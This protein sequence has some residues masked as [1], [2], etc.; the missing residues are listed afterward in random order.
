MIKEIS[1]ENLS[2]LTEEVAA[3]S[4]KV[5]AFL[6]DERL[7]FNRGK[8]VHKGRNNL[9]SYV[10]QQAEK[11]FVEALGAIFPEAGF[12]AEEGTGSKAEGGYNWVIDPLDGTTNYVH[13]IPFYCTSVALEYQGRVLLGVVYDPSRDELFAASEGQTTTLNGEPVRVSEVSTLSEM[14]MVTGFPYD[15]RGLLQ[16]NLDT[17]KDLTD[18]SRGI[19]R[20]GSAALDL[21]Y[22]ACG[23]VDGMY[24]YGLSPWDVAAGIC[25]VKQAGGKTNDFELSDNPLFNEQILAGSPEAYN[26][27]IPIVQSHFVS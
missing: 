4:R 16:A 19:R 2:Q 14:L 26:A 27:L 18:K 1:P 15:Q 10:D 6:R 13:N 25:L 8:V 3:I 12:I 9:V 23:R 20:L 11:Q 24:E 21:C 5:G 17:I 22:V 7:H